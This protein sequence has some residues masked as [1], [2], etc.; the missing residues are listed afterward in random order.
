MA[1]SQI[2]ATIIGASGYAGAELLRIL[3][4]H[5]KVGEIIATSRSQAGKPY[6]K[7]H[8][9]LRNVEGSFAKETGEELKADVVFTATPHG[10]AMNLAP[11]LGAKTKLID[12]SADFRL[13]QAEF[14]Q[15]YGMPHACPNLLKQA[16]YGLPEINRDKIRKAKIV[17]NPGCYPTSAIL[18]LYPIVKAGIP[19]GFIAVDSKSGSSGAG[20]DPSQF[21]HHPEVH[22]NLKHYKL[23]SHRHRPEIE[24]HLSL[25]SG[26]D[27]TLSFT[28]MLVPIARGIVSTCH[29]GY[30]KLNDD[31]FELY[32]R[33]YKDAPFVRVLD[34][35]PTIAPVIG[36]NYCDVFAA[37]DE[38]AKQIIA[39]GAID[40]LI[41]GASG[42]AVQ[43]MNLMFGFKETEGLNFIAG[44]V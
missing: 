22:A 33:N 3:S 32:L 40:N 41:K 39:I 1:S 20:D 30:S 12:I 17:A 27:V 13:D 25:A 36:T 11:H 18:A 2:S 38:H 10:V 31:L 44:R 26:K 4:Q 6:F 34:E 23:V 35:I 16:V 37:I 42:Q 7:V 29:V 8:P 28:P 15:T 24:R 21:L 14:E 43:N 19:N 5:G 9:N